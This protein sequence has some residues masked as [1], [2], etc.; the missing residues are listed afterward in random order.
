LLVVALR[1]SAMAKMHADEFDTSVA[2][3]R[4][5]VAEQQ[6]QWARL[7]I[8]PVLS[9][10]TSSAM[11]RL[12]DDMVV[13]LPLR[14]GSRA[15][16]EKEHLW[17]PK[18]APLLPCAIPQALA[19]GQ[20]TAGYPMPWSVC[21]WL[22]GVD[23]TNGAFDQNQTAIDLAA[24]LKTLQAIDTAGGPNAGGDPSDRGAPLHVRDD[25]TRPA[26]EACVHHFDPSSLHAIWDD[27]LAAPEW[28]RNPVWIHGDIA[29]GNLLFV[30]RQLSKVPSSIGHQWPL[31]IR[32]VSTSLPG[33]CSMPRLAAPFASTA[34]STRPHGVEPVGGR[35]QPP[36]WRC[37]TTSSP[38]N[39]CSNKPWPN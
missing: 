19:I 23:G 36:S 22:D 3:A 25:V 34:M 39:S 38:T 16:V 20:P 37:R 11:F 30:D 17:L 27:A 18:L 15:S 14:P 5:L 6:P 35:F 8:A 9:T 13:R 24:F 33:K 26:I 28:N 10:G 32:H 7:A 31:V 12:G 2:L 4:S 21:R 29:S 1:F